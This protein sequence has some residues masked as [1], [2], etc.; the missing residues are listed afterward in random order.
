MFAGN[1]FEECMQYTVR[2]IPERLD[3]QIREEARRQGKSINQVI[4][5]NLLRAFGL[6]GEAPKRRDLSAVAGTWVADSEVE[7]ALDEQRR[8][9]EEMW[10]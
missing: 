10:R 9:D 5:E 4:L 2:N 8:I 6:K 1:T 7:D 3:H